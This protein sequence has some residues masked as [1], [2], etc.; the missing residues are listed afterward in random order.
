MPSPDNTIASP[1]P[2]NN[3][4]SNND[5]VNSIITGFIPSSSKL[6]V[7]KSSIDREPIHRV[8]LDG[9]GTEEIILTFMDE[10]HIVESG[11]M[12]L[13]KGNLEWEKQFE[14]TDEYRTISL[15]DFK[16][17]TGDNLP[18]IFIG[19]DNT[20]NIYNYK[21][22]KYSLCKSI[23]FTE[24]TSSD[25]PG[26]DG[27]DKMIELLV[28]NKVINEPAVNILRWNGYILQDVSEEFPNYKLELI[29]YYKNI[30]KENPGKSSYWFNLSKLQMEANMN[31]DSLES[32][33]KAIFLESHPNTLAQYKI[34]KARILV[35]LG[36]HNE[37]IQLINNS[38]IQQYSYIP[39]YKS[40]IAESYFYRKDYK[41]AK[42]IYEEI[43][44]FPY[45]ESIQKVD[46]TIAEEKI[47]QYINRF[48]ENQLS[49]AQAELNKFGLDNNLVINSIVARG[50]VKGLRKVLIVD[51]HIAPVHAHGKDSVGAHIFYWWSNGKLY[52][53]EYT[54]IGLYS[55][56]HLSAYLLSAA[57]SIKADSDE[58]IKM[59]I[60]F[61]NNAKNK[62]DY[63]NALNQTFVFK[64]GKWKFYWK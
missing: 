44:V 2:K 60:T 38:D 47:Y 4:S 8:D 10:K 51:Y 24:Y 25:I 12:I 32:I 7:P 48:G 27:V 28:Y 20:L 61:Q 43:A 30:S 5:D 17:I 33:E 31:K 42:E 1:R 40:V 39:Y 53:K 62:N 37:A 22:K 26:Q 16:D 15:I 50:S 18:E 3:V 54:T 21:N 63:P 11:F 13:K 64:N 6:L 56:H 29:N 14:E 35:S 36:Q 45:D 49:E 34:F 23:P 59:R 57:A 55:N 46:T 9:D 19:K 41:K 52:H 58:T